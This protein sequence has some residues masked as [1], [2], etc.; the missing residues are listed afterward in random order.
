M[1]SLF[2]AVLFSASFLFAPFAVNSESPTES[3]TDCS[4][5]PLS[6]Y[7]S[8]QYVAKAI[9]AETTEKKIL[10]LSIAIRFNPENE[11]ARELLASLIKPAE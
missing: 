6:P 1:K 9:N 11:E 3:C 4:K 2:I 7:R 5:K 8:D 10:W